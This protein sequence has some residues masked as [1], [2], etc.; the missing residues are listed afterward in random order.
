MATNWKPIDGRIMSIPDMENAIA[1]V[2]FKDWKPSGGALHNTAV[3]SLKRSKDYS[4]EHWRSMWEGYY[5]GLGWSGGPHFF[6]FPDTVLFFTPITLPGVH[7]PSWNGTKFGVEMVADF[8]KEESNSGDGLKIKR[9]AVA[10]FAALYGRLGLDPQGIK[11][12]KEDPRTTHACP[13]KNIRKDEFIELVQERMGEGGEH[14]GATTSI[15]GELPVTPHVQTGIVRVALGD[16]LNMRESADAKSR[17]VAQ[18]A[19]DV[20]VEIKG[21]SMNGT[22]K[23]LF[24]E[25]NNQDGWVN[26]KYVVM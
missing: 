2:K 1:T 24:V 14:P 21:E 18:L 11:L 19:S 16:F 17:A 20:I 9:A 3:P 13:G 8:D 26:S 4:I 5:K 6:C 7:S 10:I 25:S 22:T 15:D 12:H 23:W